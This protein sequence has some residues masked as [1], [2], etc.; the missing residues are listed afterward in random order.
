M[1][2]ISSQMHLERERA[3]CLMQLISSSRLMKQLSLLTKKNPLKTFTF[4]YLLKW[5]RWFLSSIIKCL[6]INLLFWEF[7]RVKIK[8][9]K[10]ELC[11]KNLG[12]LAWK[13]TVFQLCWFVVLPFMIKSW[14]CWNL[15]SFY[16][17]PVI[18]DL[19][20]K[21]LLAWV[22]FK[23]WGYW[24]T[25]GSSF[26]CYFFLLL[27]QSRAN[28]SSIQSPPPPVVWWHCV[29]VIARL[30]LSFC[31]RD[32][33]IEEKHFVRVKNDSNEKLICLSLFSWN[34]VWSFFLLLEKTKRHWQWSLFCFCIHIWRATANYYCTNLSCSLFFFALAHTK[35]EFKT[36]PWDRIRGGSENS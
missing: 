28:K 34:L 12:V 7:S 3:L 29:W 36:L 32:D 2:V 35:K 1:M 21:L 23:N 6:S 11:F 30:L 15:L 9:L 33:F 20:A 26:F 27:E 31:R 22:D 10:I 19:A 16:N 5:C 4:V 18:Y 17:W 14:A 24:L 8:C 13:M 25:S